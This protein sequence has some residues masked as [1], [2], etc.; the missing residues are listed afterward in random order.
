VIGRGLPREAAVAPAPCEADLAGPAWHAVS[1][2]V[3]PIG[4]VERHSDRH[5]ARRGEHAVIA[6]P[7]SSA[8]DRHRVTIG[9]EAAAA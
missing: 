3:A 4:R 5:A 6:C 9:I 2:R 7:R 8:S 1:V